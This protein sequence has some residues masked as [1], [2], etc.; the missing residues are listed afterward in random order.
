MNLYKACETVAT[1]DVL[2]RGTMNLSDRRYCAKCKTAL[3]F[4]YLENRNYVI[5]CVKC[6]TKTIVKTDCP[7]RALDIVGIKKE[8]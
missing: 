4:S 5:H 6:N 2:W 7:T 1:M 8:E 3:F